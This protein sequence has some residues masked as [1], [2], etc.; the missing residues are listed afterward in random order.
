MRALVV[1][2]DNFSDFCTL[3]LPRN[4]EA[5]GSLVHGQAQYTISIYLLLGRN[6]ESLPVSPLIQWT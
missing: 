6:Q 3:R 2:F 4:N 5:M 1:C